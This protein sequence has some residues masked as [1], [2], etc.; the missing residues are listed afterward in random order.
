M[1]RFLLSLIFSFSLF[2]SSQLEH[3]TECNPQEWIQKGDR[4]TFKDRFEDKRE[5]ILSV[6]D[7]MG[8]FE[9]KEATQSHYDYAL[10]P[11]ALH[12][13]VKRRI[14]HLIKQWN[15][16]V[17]FNMIVFLT[18]QRP[19]H[20]EKEKAF[21]PLKTETA[22]MIYTWEQAKM[23]LELREV[24]LVVIDAPPLPLRGRPTTESTVYVWL[25]HNPKPGS[26]LMV[27]SQPYVGYQQAILQTLLPSFTIEGVGAEGGSSLPTSVLLDTLGKQLSWENK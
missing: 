14:D 5:E 6:L 4:W 3:I 7:S 24:P 18:G 22:M 27:S 23:P 21:L 17:R 13:S 26:I 11:G 15:Q 2:A 8:M 9:A 12:G 1:F 25:K 16:G 20:L 10:V 19:L